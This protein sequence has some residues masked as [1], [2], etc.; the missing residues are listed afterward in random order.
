MNKEAREEKGQLLNIKDLQEQH[1]SQ[2]D[3][4]TLGEMEQVDLMDRVDRKFLFGARHLERI[5]EE[6]RDN[7][8][9]LTIEEQSY[10]HLDSLYFDTPD[11]MF[12]YQHHNG[13]LNRHK[14]RFR[15]YHN[16]RLNYLEVKFKNNKG[17]TLKNRIL[18]D[19]SQEL[20]FKDN[21]T[22]FLQ[23][24]IPVEPEILSPQIWVSFTRLNF[25]HKEKHERLTLDLN[26]TFQHQEKKISFPEVVIAELKQSIHESYAD[27]AQ[28]MKNR[29]IRPTPFSKYCI[30]MC[31]LH[32]LKSN[33]FKSILL[34]LKNI[35]RH[36]YA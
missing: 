12:F 5:F 10:S 36:A 1:F 21:E 23:N 20:P 18:R 24:H 25:L 15:Y 19:S 3:P 29:Q 13:K 30:G 28:L 9:V 7:Y 2:F 33:R 4:V 11:S 8:R 27:F 22:Q 35:N 16:T 26:L 17:R 31:L 6:M 14:V 34:N 32:D